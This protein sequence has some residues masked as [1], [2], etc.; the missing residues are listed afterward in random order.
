M[1]T[2]LFLTDYVN[3]LYEK[4]TLTIILHVCIK[5]MYII[6]LRKFVSLYS[7]SWPEKENVNM[8]NLV[9]FVRFGLK[10]TTK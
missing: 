6:A 9:F 4:K 5:D 2:N 8:T 7:S 3:F 1:I 10:S